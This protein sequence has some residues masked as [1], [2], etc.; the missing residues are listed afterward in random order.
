MGALRNRSDSTVYFGRRVDGKCHVYA[1]PPEKT[2]V[3]LR[4]ELI[5]WAGGFGWGGDDPRL[6]MQL[7]FSILLHF[8]RGKDRLASRLSPAFHR[9]FL[10]LAE[11]DWKITGGQ[12][13]AWIA[14]Q[15]F[16]AAR[17]LLARAGKLEAM[18]GGVN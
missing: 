3:P 6:S 2:A 5:K 14:Q 1:V 12:I 16:A 17:R 10:L 9:E 8:T 13:R 15:Q 4:I 18:L 11:V 7:G